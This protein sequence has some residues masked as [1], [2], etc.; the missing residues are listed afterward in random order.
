LEI[1]DLAIGSQAQEPLLLVSIKTTARFASIDWSS[2]DDMT[3]TT[4][5]SSY[6]LGL[7][8]GGMTDGTV[9]VW[10]ANSLI[11]SNTKKSSNTTPSS[12]PP[13]LLF[14]IQEQLQGTVSALKFH[15]LELYRLA[16]GD[17]TGRVIVI[18]CRDQSIV[19]PTTTAARQSSEITAV[20]WN[21]Q[22]AYILASSSRD[23]SVAVWDVQQ[24]KAWCKLQVE[25]GPVADIAWNPTEGLNLLTASGDD[26]NPVIKVWDLGASTNMPLATLVGHTA[27]ILKTSWCPH[28]DTLL[29]S[30]A[31]DNR[32]FLWDL[33]TLQPVAELPPD[34][35]DPHVALATANSPNKLFSS[36]TLE[37]QKHM[38]VFTE[39]SPIKRGV[40]LTCSLDR[41]VQVHSV[42][43]L[44]TACGRPPSW[45]KPQSAVTTAF[46]GAVVSVGSTNQLVTIQTFQEQPDLAKL[47]CDFEAEL[48]AMADDMGAFCEKRRS[49]AYGYDAKI[50]GFMKV[51]FAADARKQLLSHLGFH[52]EVIAA[53]ANSFNEDSSDMNG[54]HSCTSIGMSKA[55]ED[56]VKRALLVGNFE[57]AV[58]CCFQAGNLAD[59]MVLASVGGTELWQKTQQRYFEEQKSKRP[60]LSLL[61]G[62]V[63]NDL[64]G[65]VAETDSNKWQETLA[66]L[67]TYCQSDQ[68]PQLCILLGDR[69]AELGDPQSA[70]LCYV[71]SLSVEHASRYWVEQFERANKIKGSLDI[72]ALHDLAVKVTVLLK[73]DNKA[74]VP[75]AIAPH[76]AVYASALAEQGLFVSAAKYCQGE[77]DDA[78]ILRDRLYRS[79]DSHEC[80]AA[81]GAAPA[82]PFDMSAPKKA[83]T[84]QI[85]GNGSEHSVRSHTSISSL[86]QTSNNAS[87]TSLAQA[88]A[89]SGQLPQGWAAFQDPSTGKTYYAN[90][91]T[92]ETTWDRPLPSAVSVAS[93]QNRAPAVQ[94]ASSGFLDN[95]ASLSSTPSKLVSKYGDGFVTSASHPELAAQYG[96]VGTANPYSGERPGTAESVLVHHTGGSTKLEA[97]LSEPMDLANAQFT[98]EQAQIKDTL[99]SLYDHLE[100]VAQPSE[101]RQLEESKKGIDALFKK[102]ARGQI[103]DEVNA[104]LLAIVAQIGNYD[105]RAATATQTSLVNT[106]WKI[107]KD[108]L[109]GLKVLLQ[110]A[111]KR[112]Y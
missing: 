66:L 94:A 67:A 61:K 93:H 10:D 77:S 28:D 6:P 48:A 95:S 50:W 29:L 25:Q 108:W 97:P 64:E 71:C 106:D 101:K 70:S 19:D 21:S 65:L 104:K 24:R 111:V 5:K 41:K 99:Q 27:G 43:G 100:S 81:L 69:L 73:T 105:F 36:G 35:T 85:V 18:D 47:S 103:D 112:L 26:R 80:L 8:A 13:L 62:I 54:V 79:R 96:N 14:T 82:F 37:E 20:S 58:E 63:G 86:G 44:A 9:L 60:Y 87:S 89:S 75:A 7:I 38:R 4:T 51:V 31:K 17:S 23:G 88:G 30:C 91:T 56:I 72:K 46:G 39:W 102:L 53:A 52:A 12:P 49:L 92:G 40:A 110:L 55:A 15:P 109:K 11:A 32:T 3:T 90:Q 68:F 78:M 1:Y 34:V 107:H 74:V 57:A 22:V 76:F 45:M 84:R 2:Y 33:V 98:E 59:A 16:A 42:L 83:T